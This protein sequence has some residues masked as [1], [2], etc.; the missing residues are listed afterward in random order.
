MYPD[1]EAYAKEIVDRLIAEAYQ[2]G[3]NDGY[4]LAVEHEINEI[5]SLS[6]LLKKGAR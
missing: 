5:K 6:Q 3:F 1:N 4:C 2:K